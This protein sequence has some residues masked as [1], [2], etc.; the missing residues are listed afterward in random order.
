MT[1]AIPRPRSDTRKEPVRYECRVVRSVEAN[2]PELMRP[3][4]LLEANT[5]N[6]VRYD[7]GKMGV[8]IVMLEPILRHI[9]MK[10]RRGVIP[11]EDLQRFESALVHDLGHAQYANYDIPL[12]PFNPLALYGKDKNWLG[13][14]F[15]QRDYRLVGDRAVVETY[16]RDNYEKPDGNPVSQRF[17][18]QNT[19]RL[20]PHATIGEVR[21]ENMTPEQ[22]VSF[23][24][25]PT[26]FLTRA[27]Y[28]R[29]ERDY[30]EYGIRHE[31][32]EVV[33]PETVALDGLR[34]FCQSKQ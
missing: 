30:I 33:W 34:V 25:D 1:L 15:A 18:D 8:T 20:K 24:A 16:L 7:L 19:R 13:L 26:L 9:L 12:D 10:N 3:L 22:T 28:D 11:R 17:I 27:V 32:E 5:T 31:G 14:Q 29:M 2:Q 21:Y 4:E 6:Y 23:Q